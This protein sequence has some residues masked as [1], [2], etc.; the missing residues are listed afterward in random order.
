MSSSRFVCREMRLDD[1]AAVQRLNRMNGGHHSEPTVL[2]NCGAFGGLVCM[3]EPRG[4]VCGW[5]SYL[6]SARARERPPHEGLLLLDLQAHPEWD[7]LDVFR[8]MLSHLV[9]VCRLQGIPRV[10]SLLPADCRESREMLFRCG[11]L[12]EKLPGEKFRMS[13]EVEP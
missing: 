7:A 13:L 3:P 11:M 9:D 4:P 1:W 2:T 5:L 8:S 12:C 6:N 10:F